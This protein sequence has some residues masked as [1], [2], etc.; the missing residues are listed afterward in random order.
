MPSCSYLL[1]QSQL[2]KVLNRHSCRGTST[3]AGFIPQCERAQGCI[4]I[5]WVPCL[6]PVVQ[7]LLLLL[8]ERMSL[9]CF[10]TYDNK[11]HTTL[12]IER[13]LLNSLRNNQCPVF[14]QLTVSPLMLPRPRDI[15]YHP[16]TSI[17]LEDHTHSIQDRWSAQTWWA[18]GPV[19]TLFVQTKKE[20][21][22]TL[23]W[24]NDYHLLNKVQVNAFSV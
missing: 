17:Q 2:F 18:A 20:T 3:V 4:I 16:I 24:H 12:S 8:Q 15:Q 6:P 22:S 19:S 5:Y 9:F 7:L 11:T 21:S 1:C 10:R 14:N 23:L 13:L